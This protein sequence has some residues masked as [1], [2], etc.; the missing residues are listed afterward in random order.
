M[1]LEV[2]RLAPVVAGGNDVPLVG[3]AVELR[4][5]HPVVLAVHDVMAQLHVLQDLGQSQQHYA[6]NPRR[7]QHAMHE[8]A[9]KQQR[10][11]GHAGPA[12]RR[13]DAANVARIGGADLALHAG[14]DGIELVAERLQ[15][16]SGQGTVMDSAHEDSLQ[17]QDQV[18]ARGTDAQADLC[19]GFVAALTG[20]QVARGAGLAR[21]GAAVADA[22]A[23]AVFGPQAL[24][25][26]AF[27]QRLAARQGERTA[28]A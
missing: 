15:F 8:R 26:Q 20:Q 11:T 2:V 14:A 18:S 22:H 10:A 1:V 12:H 25:F 24:R 17:I 5:A 3:V 28:A 16:G 9:Q 19:G 13:H 23:A 27:Q 7:N 6:G 21:A 4:V